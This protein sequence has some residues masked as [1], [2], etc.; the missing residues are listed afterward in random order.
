MGWPKHRQSVLTFC[1]GCLRGSSEGR[2]FTQTTTPRHPCGFTLFTFVSL[3][4]FLY[5]ARPGSHSCAFAAEAPFCFMS[6]GLQ[7][8][9]A[10]ERVMY[11]IARRAG[12]PEMLSSWAAR[13]VAVEI[14]CCM[15]CLCSLAG[16]SRCMSDACHPQAVLGGP[17]FY[18]YMLS[19]HALRDFPAAPKLRPG[20]YVCRLLSESGLWQRC[21]PAFRLLQR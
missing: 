3:C 2:V 18:A 5:F 13:R 6:F 7:S 17:G 20:R 4:R 14:G 19:Q 16:P 11:R 12:P 9:Q 1:S 15:A 10:G 21:M 8:E